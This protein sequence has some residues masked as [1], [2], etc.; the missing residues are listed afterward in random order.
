M[1]GVPGIQQ[2]PIAPKSSF[3]Y[4]FIAD[5]YGTTWYHSHYSAQY[6]AGI[7]GPLV[8]HGPSTEPY[9]IGQYERKRTLDIAKLFPDIGPVLLTDHFH[10]DYYSLVEQVMSTDQ[11]VPVNY[12]HPCFSSILILVARSFCQQPY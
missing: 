6:A 3:T 5:L 12:L 10:D 9:D 7:F 1:D 11:T 8:I 4:R 2:C